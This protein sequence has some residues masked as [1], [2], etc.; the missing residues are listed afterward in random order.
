[1]KILVA[2]P[3][4]NITVFVLDTIES[5]AKRKAIARAIMAEKK[6][7][8]EQVGF[9]FPPGFSSSG[10]ARSNALW[11]LEMS[12]GEFCGNAARSFGLYVARILKLEGRTKI[13]VSVSGADEPVTVELDM[14]KSLAAAE[15]PKPKTIETLDYSGR[16]LP[17][18]CF[19][20][21][22]HIIAAGIKP[23]R[24]IFFDILALAEKKLKHFPALGVM[25]CEFTGANSA[26]LAPAR[27]A[28]VLMQP[29]VYVRSIDSF[30]FESSCGSGSSAMGAWLSR[31]MQNGAEKYAISQPGG[32][33]E[34]EVIKR[35]G[36]IISI[37]I[38]GEVK[39]GEPEDFS[40]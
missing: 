3:A 4:G 39:L 28:S 25:F 17:A 13:T 6:F 26:G 32:I 1:M 16:Y 22:T 33:I 5:S 24:K 8:A 12:G 36:E 18:L 9:V 40:T 21:I 2:N 23:D 20:G 7:G 11:H 38:G 10:S 14:E 30:V 27:L 19:E 37:T 34:T 15:L 35:A 31:E 29:A